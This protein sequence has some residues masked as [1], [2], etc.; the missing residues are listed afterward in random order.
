MTRP[1]LPEGTLF[2]G[3]YR[4]G[5]LIAQGGMG[6]V[7]LVHQLS[8]GR[9]RAL[10]VMHPQL[11]ENAELRGRFAQEARIGAKIGSSHVVDV[12]AAGIDE[13]TGLPYL[14]MEHLEGQ[15]L[16]RAVR[17]NGAFPAAEVATIV[18]Q[19]GHALGAAHAAGIVHRDL[20]PE[21]VF[22]AR[23]RRA[24]S[25]LSV[26]ILDFG[27][28][29][30]LA[31]GTTNTIAMGSPLWLAPEQT[32]PGPVGYAADLWS[33]GLVV[34]FLLVGSP[35][36][37]C[38]QLGSPTVAAIL[39]EVLFDEIVPPSHRATAVGK[40]LPAGFDAW[41]ARAV[42]R[43]PK[44]RFRN[45]GEALTELLPVLAGQGSTSTGPQTGAPQSGS[46]RSVPSDPSARFTYVAA[47]LG[48]VVLAGCAVTAW[49]VLRRKPVTSTLP[50]ASISALSTV[51]PSAPP[52]DASAPLDRAIIDAAID[53]ATVAPTHAVSALPAEGKL[54]EGAAAKVIGDHSPN[55][56]VCYNEA[57]KRDPTVDGTLVVRFVI[58]P[59]GSV[60]S[61][62][63][64][65]STIHDPAFRS[66]VFDEI[67]T[68]QFPKPTGGEVTVDLPYRFE[69]V[70]GAP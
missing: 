68:W 19:L 62:R 3:D 25:S 64:S 63:D 11:V 42:V 66:C 15:D 21:N 60:K 32:E 45:V 1:V 10:K 52:Q 49:W 24:D 9:D 8:T 36:W 14:V 6:A 48:F 7:Y 33:F 44:A 35:Y 27:I 13:P 50:S 51:A 39:K 59:D 17:M 54:P 40:R 23:E 26:K 67:R 46:P 37:R 30:L 57:V 43:D 55:V 56:R 22:L 53:V 28:A 65:G 20:K 18:T 29:K 61:V 58:S 47:T 16:G 70:K 38:V 2:A 41:F 12:Q 5:T 4:V 69:T 31:E 34:Y